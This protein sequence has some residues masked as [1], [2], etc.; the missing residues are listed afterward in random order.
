MKIRHLTLLLILLAGFTSCKTSKKTSSS[1]SSNLNSLLLLNNTSAKR[2]AFDEAFFEGIKNSLVENNVEKAITNFKESLD[3]DPYD[4]GA[5]Y[6]LANMYIRQKK[7][8][9]AA[10]LLEKAV[11]LDKYNKWYRFALS[12][13]YELQKKYD[14]AS[15]IFETLSRMYPYDQDIYFNLADLYL[16]DNQPAKAIKIYDLLEGFMGISPEISDQK[17]RIYLRMDKYDKAVEEIQKLIRAY[18]ENT[19]YIRALVDLYLANGHEVLVPDLYQRILSID[20]ND[21]RALLVMADYFM[22]NNQPEKSQPLALRALK[23]KDLDIESKLTFLLFTYGK[24]TL[25]PGSRDDLLNLVDTVIKVHP[26]NS[27][28]FAFK[29]DIYY[30]LKQSDSA[31]K[32][33]KKALDNEK[34]VILLW[35]KII[36]LNFDKK[37]YKEAIKTGELTLEYFPNEPEIYFYMGIAWVQLKDQKKAA[38]VLETGLKYV[39]N[40]KP[41]EQQYYSNLAE[42]YNDL[43]EYAKS[44]ENYDKALKIDPNDAIALNNY[45]Y[46]LSL[47]KTRLDDAEKMSKKSMVLNPNSAANL[48]TYAWILY[49]QGDFKNAE[50]YILKALSFSPADPDILEHYGDILFKSGGVEKA[51][52]QWKK[53][54]ENGSVSK[55]ID[56]KIADQKLY[57]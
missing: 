30:D 8:E 38:E 17:K 36:L 9:E 3:I 13:V 11:D 28:P 53:A 16:L 33:Y 52:E 20:S 1:S 7:F 2:M 54:K 4:P 6:E 39:V 19:D 51:V 25:T 42:C 15:K 35:K 50:S 57:E 49:L 5:M 56:R 55:L 10:L 34:S 41:L 40:N 46:Y 32:Y 45:A 27:K 22:R 18:P 44:D 24:K 48:D 21:G 47:R 23:N 26:G 43:A 14:K 12:E 31:L 29:A 37:D